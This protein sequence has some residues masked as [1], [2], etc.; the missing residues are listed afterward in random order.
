MKIVKNYELFYIAGMKFNC[1][2]NTFQRRDLKIL[3]REVFSALHIEV[4]N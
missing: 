4:G 1:L 2:L 3:Q